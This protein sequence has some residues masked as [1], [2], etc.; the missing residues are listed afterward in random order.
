MHASHWRLLASFDIQGISLGR[1]ASRYIFQ[2]LYD[3]RKTNQEGI[4]SMDITDS[5][6]MRFSILDGERAEDCAVALVQQGL[7]QN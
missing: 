4:A 7:V 3:T 1:R 2:L 6:Q 5:M